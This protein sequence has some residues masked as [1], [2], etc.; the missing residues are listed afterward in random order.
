V[1]IENAEATDRVM[2]DLMGKDPEKRFRFIM[3]RAR[4]AQSLDI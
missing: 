4:D 3:D 1:I 2:S